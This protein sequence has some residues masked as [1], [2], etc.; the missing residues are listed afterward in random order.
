M[1]T[2]KRGSHPHYAC[3]MKYSLSKLRN[4]YADQM[5]STREEEIRWK[6]C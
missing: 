1:P 4:P 3:Y 5:C 2:Y 6:K